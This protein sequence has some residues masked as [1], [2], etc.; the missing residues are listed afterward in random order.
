MIRRLRALA[1]G[2]VTSEGEEK[3]D[4]EGGPSGESPRQPHNKMKHLLMTKGYSP[5]TIR[6]ILV[7]A[8]PR[9]V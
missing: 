2:Q 9:L 8:L 1:L 3:K 5:E 4:E 7:E 6:T